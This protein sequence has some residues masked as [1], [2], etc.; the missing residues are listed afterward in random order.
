MSCFLRI[1]WLMVLVGVAGIVPGLVQ[2]AGAEEV[3]EEAPAKV[4]Q[5]FS[6]VEP[7]TDEVI[8][9][10]KI[11]SGRFLDQAAA[12]GIEPVLVF[13]FRAGDTKPGGTSSG[14]AA[15]LA[16]FLAL[17]LRAAK[18]TV[19]YVPEPLSGYAVMAALACDDLVLGEEASLGP[20][21]PEGEPV[22]ETAR[23][24][25]ENIARRK[26]RDAGLLLGMLEPEAELREVKTADGQ[27]R[28]VFVDDL[29]EFKKESQIVAESPAWE[30]GR[31]GVVRAARGRDLGLVKLIANGR[32]KLAETYGMASAADD[33]TLSGPVRA[34][35]VKI[36]GAIDRVK[37]SYLKRRISQAV[38]NE[39][40]NLMVFQLNTEGGEI[41]PT[42]QVAR[43]IAGLSR[44]GVKTVAFVDDRVLG[45]SALMMLACDEVVVRSG[46]KIGSG[47]RIV[48]GQGDIGEIDDGAVQKALSKTAV[49]LARQKFHPEAVAQALLDPKVELV[50]AIDNQ[51]GA[52][53]FLTRE[54]AD[55]EPVRFNVL[56]TVKAVGEEL[57]LDAETALEVGLSKRTATSLKEWLGSQGLKN[58]R[59]DG[60][61][62]VDSLVTTLNE[63]WMSGLLLF[64]GIFMLILEL[65]LP[66]VGLPAICSA[67]AFLLYFW[68]HYL[69][70]TADRLEIMLFLV[71]LVC[72]ALELFV[73]PG[74]GVFGMSGILLVLSSV[75]MASHTFVWPTQDYQYRQMGRTLTSVMLTIVAVVGG[76]VVLGRYFPS[77]PLFRRMILMPE[78]AD[79]V[80][81]FASKPA[82]AYDPDSSLFFLIGET[83]KTT[84]VCKPSG[85]AR[86]G[87]RLVDVYADGF[88]I[89]ANVPVEVIEVRGTRV[90]V[91]KV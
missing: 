38:N 79:A 56:K 41:D 24:T 66:G 70:G 26:G 60:P 12:R 73:F 18:R 34:V 40:V 22:S 9:E 67:L 43:M 23:G 62:W 47:V 27:T 59:V 20:I 69:G 30:G 14:N 10:I 5:F 37:E 19:A 7:V 48:D 55:A 84:T 83:G 85:K 88:Y 54:A 53:V 3:K 87:E 39:R 15:D 61:T 82:E 42:D 77:L 81:D 21:T 52:S 49:D 71:G 6:V 1:H 58:I 13:E 51:S 28:F 86:F 46:S 57:T 75:V 32:K 78:P 4:G 76:V 44:Q 36:D 11:A 29:A 16:D 63:P 2:G 33:P 31:R 91:K 68:G 50:E 89:E 17:K 74:F 25:L 35:L 45:L 64:I 8:E 90:W 80:E 65:K 72:L